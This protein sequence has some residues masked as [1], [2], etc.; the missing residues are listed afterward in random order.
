MAD[1][2]K[3][4]PVARSIELTAASRAAALVSSGVQPALAVV[5]VGDRP[6]DIAYERGVMKRCSSVGVSV[7]NMALPG[8]CAERRL[9]DI[10]HGLS[11]DPS[12]HGAL[13]FRPLPKYMNDKLVRNAI[14]PQKDVDG[15]TDVSL[16]GVFTGLE[17]GYS[18]CTAQACIEMLKYYGIDMKGKRAVVV[19]RSLVVGRPVAMMLLAGDATVTMCHTRTENMPEVCRS[20]DILVVSAGREAMIGRDYLAPGQVVIDVGINV[21][22]DGTLCGDVDYEAAEGIVGAVTP[23]PGGVGSVTTS[24]L[25]SH[26]VDAAERMSRQI[27]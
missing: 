10:L 2:L 9:V 3:G 21:R 7:R 27:G 23:V 25:V 17:G 6:D 18:P 12:V 1:V 4:I 13:L 22:D 24:V 11:G 16:C 8:D 15:V 5:R 19:G 14:V 20:A 26:V